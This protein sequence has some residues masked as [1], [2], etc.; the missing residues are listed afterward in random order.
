MNLLEQKG[1]NLVTKGMKGVTGLE[2][3]HQVGRSIDWE[4]DTGVGWGMEP[5]DGWGAST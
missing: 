5:A 3:R 1:L 2:K 4:Q